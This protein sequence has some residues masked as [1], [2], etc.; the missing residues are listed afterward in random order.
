[1]NTDT[2]AVLQFEVW[3]REGLEA[4]HETREG[5]EA[6]ARTL[7]ESLAV[8]TWVLVVQEARP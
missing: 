8:V 4:V 1:M 7:R 3:S 6:Y 2:R 5:A